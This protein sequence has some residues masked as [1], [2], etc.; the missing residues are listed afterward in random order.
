MNV[1]TSYMTLAIRGTEFASVPTA[2]AGA[3][4]PC[5]GRGP[6]Q[7]REGRGSPYPAASGPSPPPGPA[8]QLYTLARPRDAVQWS[9][10]YPP[11]FSARRGRAEARPGAAARRWQRR[12]RVPLAA[13][14]RRREP[15]PPPQTCR[16]ALLPQRPRHQARTALD[17]ALAADPDS[18]DALA[19]RAIIHVVRNERELR[20][21]TP[22]GRSRSPRLGCGRSLL[23]YAQQAAFDSTERA[24]TCC[25]R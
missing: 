13:L 25:R 12:R 23:S 10:F 15:S 2:S 7:Q 5:R 11:I 1:N 19:L 22:A 16:A 20:S 9:L 8:A 3:C 17:A 18:G 24:Q 14:D 4:R 21:P 6:G